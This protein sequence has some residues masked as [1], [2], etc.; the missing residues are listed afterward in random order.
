MGAVVASAALTVLVVTGC[1][2]EFSHYYLQGRRSRNP[3]YLLAAGG[4]F[5]LSISILG[6]EALQPLLHLLAEPQVR[7]ASFL[8]GSLF[9]LAAVLLYAYLTNLSPRRLQFEDMLLRQLPTQ[10]PDEEDGESDEDWAR[11]DKS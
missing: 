7:F 11:K 10:L 8:A 9:L 1:L 6:N 2:I 4:L 5:L 3:S